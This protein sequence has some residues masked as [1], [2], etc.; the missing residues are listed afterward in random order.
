MSPQ[1][2]PRLHMVCWRAAWGGARL[3]SHAEQ[4]RHGK[5]AWATRTSHP[6]ARPPLTLTSST[7]TKVKLVPAQAIPVASVALIGT[8]RALSSARRNGLE[9]VGSTVVAAVDASVPLVAV[10]ATVA[11]AAATVG[12]A[13]D[14][15]G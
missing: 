3:A 5:L 6:T 9:M 12:R 15:A 7:D 8:N 1:A 4:L 13:A 14:A 11:P 10:A 2:R